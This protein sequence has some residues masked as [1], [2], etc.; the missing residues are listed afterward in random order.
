MILL[1]LEAAPHGQPLFIVGGYR[2]T[3]GTRPTFATPQQAEAYDAGF[4][5]WWWGQPVPAD[6]AGADGWHTAELRFEKSR[7]DAEYA[8]RCPERNE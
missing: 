2:A 5:S 3:S 6:A 1:P 8:T 4:R 7:D